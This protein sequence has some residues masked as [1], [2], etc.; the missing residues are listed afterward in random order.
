MITVESSAIIA[1]PEEEVFAFVADQRNEPKWHTDVLDI[2]PASPTDVGGFGSSW[3]VTVKFMGRNEY[4]VEVTAF[5]PN[6]RVE[7]TTMSGP[8]RPVTN[9]LLEAVGSGTR[10]I[11]RVDIPVEGKF[12]LMQP[13]MQ[14]SAHRRNARFVQ[15]LKDLLEQ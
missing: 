1:R 2:E 4:A 12:R 10:F 5:E 11:R 14:R 8:L 9:Y 3:L 7:I 6:R 15:N 13:L